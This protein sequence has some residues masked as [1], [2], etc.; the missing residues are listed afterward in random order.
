MSRNRNRS[1]SRPFFGVGM[2]GSSTTPVA[3]DA[4]TASVERRIAM[5]QVVQAA[6]SDCAVYRFVGE[7]D[8]LTAPR[9]RQ[10]LAGMVSSP[11]VVIDLS[12][13]VFIDSTGLNALVGGIRRIRECGGG[14]AVSSS[15]PQVR[16]LLTLTGF[17]K[18]VLLADSVDE[19]AEKFAN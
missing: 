18:I 13:V 19:A 7:L 2:L 15:S 5:S 14:V 9:L 6:G 1:A 3:P 8:A 12:E 10:V 17:D 4:V 16:R 11:K